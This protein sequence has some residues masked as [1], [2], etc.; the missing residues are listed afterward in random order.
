MFESNRFLVFT[1]GL[2][3]YR[4]LAFYDKSKKETLVC[5]TQNDLDF[6]YYQEYW[7]NRCIG[8]NNDIDNFVPIGT[9]INFFI[10]KNNEYVA[11]IPAI[12]IKRWFDNN[13]EEVEKLPAHLK[14]FSSINWDDN[15]V[16]VVMKLKD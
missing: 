13:P 7:G 14:E 12:E 2:N 11:A 9:S 8:F 16:V 4:H 10:N 1:V 3:G 15:P 5:N 6:Y